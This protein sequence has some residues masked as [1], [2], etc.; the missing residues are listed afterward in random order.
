MLHSSANLRRSK[1]MPQHTYSIF[2]SFL[3]AF[4]LQLF[5][6]TFGYPL[7]IHY[8]IPPLVASFY[9]FSLTSVLWLSFICGA[10]ADCFFSM[11]RLG[12]LTS[13]YLFAALLLYKGRHYFFKDS[14]T[15]LG[16]LT[17]FFSFLVST[18]AIFLA[19]LFDIST[20]CLLFSFVSELLLMPCCDALYAF[21]VF[22]LPCL[23]FL[24][25]HR[26]SRNR[27]VN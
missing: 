23:L 24:R 10:L 7:T 20:S 22:S 3:I 18:F 2:L 11:P 8:F 13:S 27:T 9:A 25:Y 6:P 17:F 15:T 5:A 19:F 12:F 4:I 1:S 16:I 14:P 21:F 26:S